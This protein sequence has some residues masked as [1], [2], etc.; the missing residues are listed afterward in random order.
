MA[1]LS[2]ISRLRELADS[3][4]IPKLFFKKFIRPDGRCPHCSTPN[5]TFEQWWITNGPVEN[6][7][8]G[9]QY[10]WGTYFC[11]ACGGGL[12]ARGEAGGKGEDGPITLTIPGPRS[13]HEDLPPMA[14]RF[15][16]QAMDT[17]HAPDA[18]AM[19]AGSA[20]DAMLKDIGYEKGS[21]YERINL[22]VK[23]H[24][25]TESMGEWAH[26]VR[27]GSNRPRHADTERPHVLP[28]E[29]AQAVEFAES[30]GHFLFVLTKRIERGRLAATEA[31][32]PVTTERE[33]PKQQGR[34]T[35]PD[36]L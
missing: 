5:P 19:T 22:A 15:L 2:G 30:L 26:E 20:V 1:T 16:Q 24:K 18:A 8:G 17:L 14:K 34:K 31:S 9:A 29:A 35:A 27:L 10:P 23:D 7:L 12:L 3:L 6:K 4:G 28:E 11:T 13:V 36:A 25:L 21:V 33:E 32:N